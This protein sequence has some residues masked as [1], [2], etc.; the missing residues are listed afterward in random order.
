MGHQNTLLRRPHPAGT[1]G[2]RLRLVVLAR[3]RLDNGLAGRRSGRLA[4]LARHC[5]VDG[6]HVDRPPRYWALARI[7]QEGSDI[8][9]KTK[10][11]AWYKCC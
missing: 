3:R 10:A 5:Q 1:L 9:R 4:A 11:S 8:G 6:N 2:G 7:I